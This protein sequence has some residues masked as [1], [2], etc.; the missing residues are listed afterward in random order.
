MTR[1]PLGLLALAGLEVALGRRFFLRQVRQNNTTT[2]VHLLSVLAHQVGPETIE[3]RITRPLKGLK[4]AAHYGCHALRPSTITKFD[5][6]QTPSLY[7][8]LI[9]ATGADALDWSL[10]TECCGNPFWEKNSL[11]SLN[12]TRKK[13]E[14]AL[15]VEA[16]LMVTGCTYCQ[17]QFETL[18]SQ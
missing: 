17:L 12:L 1:S 14:S 11:L 6:P 7:E 15:A 18:Y 4:I 16:D 13:V 9:N 10:R 2:V 3:S 8:S 5:N